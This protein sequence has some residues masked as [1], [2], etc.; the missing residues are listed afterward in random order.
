MGLFFFFFFLSCFPVMDYSF[1]FLNRKKE[2][3]IMPLLQ[4][5][6]PLTYLRSRFF[7]SF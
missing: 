7:S 4:F 6:L 3:G 1:M 5:F 2:G